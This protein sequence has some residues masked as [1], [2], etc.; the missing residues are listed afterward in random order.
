MM[1]ANLIL[2]ESKKGKLPIV[3]ENGELVALIARRDLIK[4]RRERKG[5][6]KGERGR[7][8]VHEDPRVVISVCTY[9]YNIMHF[10]VS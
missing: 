1:E 4:V 9:V 5:E 6:R 2:R 3:G 7:E 10:Y 8:G